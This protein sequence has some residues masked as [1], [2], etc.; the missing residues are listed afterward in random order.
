MLQD[1]CYSCN[2]D[3]TLCEMVEIYQ[4]QSKM[5]NKASKREGK[6]VNL[7]FNKAIISFLS[8]DFS[9]VYYWQEGAVGHCFCLVLL[10]MSGSLES[11]EV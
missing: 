2:I 8:E 9:T 11:V 5:I 3:I 6:K 4:A 1:I 10:L 7:E